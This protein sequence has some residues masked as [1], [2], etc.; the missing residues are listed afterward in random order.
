MFNEFYKT[1]MEQISIDHIEHVIGNPIFA[2]ETS[3]EPL[4]K[5]IKEGRKDEALEIVTS[6]SNSIN[7]MKNELHLMKQLP[8]N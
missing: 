8:S 2:L 6:M 3:I 4:I 5:R 1:L 7:K